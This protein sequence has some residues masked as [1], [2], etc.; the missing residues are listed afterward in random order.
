MIIYLCFKEEKEKYSWQNLILTNRK[1]STLI[2]L[3]IQGEN[4]TS[5]EAVS[6]KYY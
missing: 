3:H 1:N 4:L 5:S 6:K 2:I